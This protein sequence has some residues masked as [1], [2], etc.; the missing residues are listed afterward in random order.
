[1]KNSYMKEPAGEDLGGVCPK[2]HDTNGYLNV[3]NSHFGVCDE[4]KVYWVIGGNLFS[5]WM[6]E[7]ETIWQENREL[8]ESYE[9]VD[10][11][12]PAAIRAAEKLLKSGD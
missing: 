4:H 8:L 9:G 11:Y 12:Y 5:C 2:C 3:E 1:M 6:Y 10:S 7:D